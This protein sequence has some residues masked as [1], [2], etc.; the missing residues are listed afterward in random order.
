[1]AAAKNTS[2]NLVATVKKTHDSITVN[3]KKG[4]DSVRLRWNRY[5][6]TI[7]VTG[8]PFTNPEAEVVA[9]HFNHLRDDMSSLKVKSLGEAAEAIKGIAERATSF[10]EFGLNFAGGSVFKK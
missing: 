4:V 5:S 1:M 6:T 9:K 10:N 7:A 2:P 3:I 8:T